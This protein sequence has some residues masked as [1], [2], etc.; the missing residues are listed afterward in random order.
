[1][2]ELAGAISPTVKTIKKRIFNRN[3]N[4]LS[5]DIIIMPSLLVQL[6]AIL[7]ATEVH[8]HCVMRNVSAAS[9]LCV[10]FF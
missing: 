4:D 7:I 2:W 1:M 3:G 10:M 5:V 9:A 6:L 8:V